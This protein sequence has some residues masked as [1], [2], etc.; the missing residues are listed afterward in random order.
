MS[1]SWFIAKGVRGIV[2]AFPHDYS[3]KI[4]RKLRHELSSYSRERSPLGSEVGP[5]YLAGVRRSLGASYDINDFEPELVRWINTVFTPADT[6]W[7]VGGHVGMYCIY[8]AKR[9]PGLRVFS[10]EPGAGS[11]LEL[12]GNLHENGVDAK[13]KALNLALADK[14]GLIAMPLVSFEPGFTT[15]TRPELETGTLTAELGKQ[16]VTGIAGDDFAKLFGAAP[17]HIKIDVDGA[18]IAIIEGARKT[19]KTCKSL[20]IESIGPI[21]DQFETAIAPILAEAGLKEIPIVAPTSARNRVFVRP[22]VVAATQI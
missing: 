6:F 17:D 20:L 12:V 2:G 18:E 15:T 5:L 8:A 11:Y 22:G 9:H 16:W 4:A 19:L 10:F 13:V 21:A 3:V 1:L 7:D 14:T